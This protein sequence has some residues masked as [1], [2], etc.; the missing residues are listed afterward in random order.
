MMAIWTNLIGSEGHWST[1]VS[2]NCTVEVQ[3][4][5][6]AKGITAMV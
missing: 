3:G 5:A 6:L 1:V 4:T 2:V